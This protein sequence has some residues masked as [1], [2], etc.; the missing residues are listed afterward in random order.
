MNKAIIRTSW[1]DNLRSFLTLLVVAHH[2]SLAY[3]T[4]AKFDKTNYMSSTAPVVDNSRWIVMDII[5]GFNDIFFMSL[6]F[7]ISGLYFYRSIAKKGKR[8]FLSD[9]VLRLGLPF[10]IVVTLIMPLAYYPSFYLAEQRTSFAAFI[11]DFIFHQHWPAGPAWF[12]WVLLAFNLLAAIIPLHYFTASHT[13]LMKLTQKPFGF[14]SLFFVLAAIA[15]TPLSLTVGQFTWTAIGP[16]AFQLN[17]I[18]LYFL[19]FLFGC[20][21]GAP[22]WEGQFFTGTKMLNQ[23]AARWLVLSMV[24]F[25][26]FG[27]YAGLA[28]D[29]VKTSRMDRDIADFIFS[30]LFVSSCI[31]SSLAFIAFFRKRIY[32]SGKWWKSLSANA[33]GIYLVHYIFVTWIQFA[34]L[35]LPVPVVVKFAVVFLGALLLS[36]LFI[37]QLRKIVWINR[38]IG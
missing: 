3:T 26:I 17:R 34:L 13:A 38:L 6:M 10:A 15:Y 28:Q 24:C 14:L 35:S 19:F 29:L 18:L 5:E 9:R 21:I 1:I 37:Q 25:F 27:F 31:A 30:L 20:C 32:A 22:D 12:I 36:F 23:S 7:L 4:F 11:H 33:Y 8:K 16:F 2:S